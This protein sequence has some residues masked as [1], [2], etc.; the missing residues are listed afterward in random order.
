MLGCFL[1]GSFPVSLQDLLLEC[2]LVSISHQDQI[3]IIDRLVHAQWEG[4]SS[5]SED[6]TL[7]GAL[8]RSWEVY[9]KTKTEGK[10]A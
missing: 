1:E 5:D 3:S 7:T 8:N 4:E 9:I 10:E 6:S 2:T